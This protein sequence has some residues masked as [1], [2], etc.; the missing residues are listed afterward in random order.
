VILS[1]I[2]A[3][4]DG[5]ELL[6]ACLRSLRHALDA[7]E[8]ETEII[9]VDNGSHDGAPEAVREAFPDARVIELGENRGFGAAVNAGVHAS[10]GEWVL[11][12]NDDTTIA[13]DAA[14]ELMAAATRSPSTGSVAAQLRFLR[15]GTIN[16]AGFGVDRLGVAFDR[17]LGEPPGAGENSVTETFGACGAAALLR[18]AMLEDVGGF[19]ESFFMYL[20]DVDLAWR[21]RMRGWRCLY[22]PAAVVRHHHSASS[23]HGSAFKHEHVGRNRV[24]LL[25][26]HAPTAHL[27]RYGPAMIAY[28]LALVVHVALTDRTLAPLR[29]RCLGLLE[30]RIYRAA[31]R[32]RRPVPL[33]PSQ[34]LA[35]ALARRRGVLGGTANPQSPVR[36]ATRMS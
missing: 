24:R 12:L 16:S 2:V 22:A 8:G 21:A 33:A 10:T 27:V 20:E 11:L 29:G 13:A 26:K 35:K 18:R 7:V 5:R 4:V 30:W 32:D 3:T 19:D 9:V 25:A 34:G 28:D 36:R 31:G 14:V 1:A 23:G 15:G 17:H 6:L